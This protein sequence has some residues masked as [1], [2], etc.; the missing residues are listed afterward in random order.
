MSTQSIESLLAVAVEAWFSQQSRDPFAHFYLYF[1]PATDRRA[2]ELLIAT[3]AP[4]GFELAHGERVSPARTREFVQHWLLP[5]VRR[6]PLLA[7]G[8]IGSRTNGAIL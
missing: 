5:V 2:G 3:D 6:L 4:V 7:H 8:E 1:R